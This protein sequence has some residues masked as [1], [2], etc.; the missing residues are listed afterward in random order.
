MGDVFRHIE[1]A[2]DK[3][4]YAQCRHRE[5]GFT[6]AEMLTDERA[7]RHAG[8]QR[9]GQAGKHDGNRAGGFFLGH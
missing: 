3:G 9:H 2:A 7:Q 1:Q 4:D 8:N 6:P 5:K